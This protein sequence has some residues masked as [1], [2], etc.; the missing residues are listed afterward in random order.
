MLNEGLRASVVFFT[1][2][3]SPYE[4]GNPSRVDRSEP[5]GM[6]SQKLGSQQTLRWREGKFEPS[7]PLRLVFES[8][9]LH[10]GVMRTFIPSQ[11]SGIGGR[12]HKGLPI[13]SKPPTTAPTKP[14]NR[15]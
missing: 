14:S 7:V 12:V 2:Y 15:S 9:S 3:R 10:G 11:Y 6:R 8:L 5:G 13:E 4:P 1:K